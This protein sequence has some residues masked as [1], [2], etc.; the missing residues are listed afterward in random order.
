MT[1]HLRRDGS[2]RCARLLDSQNGQAKP[3]DTGSTSYR[4]ALAKHGKD[5]SHGRR[6]ERYTE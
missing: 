1:H 2:V 3:R 4:G 5:R 6:T